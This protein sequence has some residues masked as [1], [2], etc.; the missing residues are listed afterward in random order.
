M[1]IKC[2]DD[3]EMS[4][5]HSFDNGR[6]AGTVLFTYHPSREAE[7]KSMIGGLLPYLKWKLSQPAQ[8]QAQNEQFFESRLYPYFSEEA[9]ELAADATWDAATHCVT[10]AIDGKTDDLLGGDAQF[11]QLVE[12]DN[13]DEVRPTITT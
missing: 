10:G 6:I 8:T 5:W 11:A 7:V 12:I 13:M 1:E 3:P 4:L 9:K 2:R